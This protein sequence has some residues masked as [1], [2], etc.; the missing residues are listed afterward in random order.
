MFSL[1]QA[2]RLIYRHPPPLRR[3]ATS[4]SVGERGWGPASLTSTS[5][6]SP[7]VLEDH[8]L[9]VPSFGGSLVVISPMSV[10][11]RPIN[12]MDFPDMD[13]ATVKVTAD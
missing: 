3:I 1:G 8:S 2:A 9:T 4:T 7:A 6:T 5:S 10:D 11:V 13:R 12:P